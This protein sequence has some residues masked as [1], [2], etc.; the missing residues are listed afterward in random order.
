LREPVRTYR[1]QFRTGLCDLKVVELMRQ[2]NG[3]DEKQAGLRINA[4]PR[5]YVE[6]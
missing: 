1:S 5:L 3:M 2:F 6:P 4:Q